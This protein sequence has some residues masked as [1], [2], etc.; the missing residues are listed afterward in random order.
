MSYWVAGAV[1]VGAAAG[2]FGAQDSRHAAENAAIQQQEQA[3]A[4]AAGTRQMTGNMITNATQY[5]EMS[6]QEMNVLSKSYDAASQNVAQQQKLMASIDPALMEAS[7]QAL[8]ILQGGQAASQAPIMAMRNSQRA[9]LVQSLRAQHGPGAELTSLG[10]RALQQF[11]L[12]SNVLQQQTLGN[13]MNM[14]TNPN[15]SANLARSVDSLNSVGQ[16]YS[17]IQT[18]KTN[19]QLGVG[20][21]ALGAL[22]QSNQGLLQ[23]AGANQV[24]AALQGQAMGQLGTNL[25]NG[26]MTLGM[27]YNMRQPGS[28]GGTGG[29]V[30]PTAG[31][32]PQGLQQPS[33]GSG[34]NNTG[35]GL[36]NSNG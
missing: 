27:M 19:T 15:P 9:Q 12:Q 21:T 35:Y 2:Y 33:M 20:S 26:G 13:L 17:A 4:N 7:K 1:T 24:G 10:Q 14:A 18:R 36:A 23:A 8:S 22:G 11:D 34:Y 31:W 28:T 6:P 16:G 29:G 32:N 25:A 3:A 5:A 30:D